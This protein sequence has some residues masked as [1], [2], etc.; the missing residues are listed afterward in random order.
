[1]DVNTHSHPPD[2]ETYMRSQT[3][4]SI[5]QRIREDPMQ[6]MCKVYEAVATS[7]IDKNML[8]S[9]DSLRSAMRRERAI[10]VPKL[11]K[12]RAEIVLQEEWSHTRNGDNFVIPNTD[13]TNDILMFSTSKNLE[14]LV[15]CK[16][17]YIDGTFKTCPKLYTQLFTMHGL[18]ID[19]VVPLVY[20]LLSDKR[21]DTYY[22]VLNSIRDAVSGLGLVFNP[23]TI[24]SDFEAGFIDAIRKQF[25]NATHS[26][27][28]FHFAQAIWRKIQDGGLVVLYRLDAEVCRFVQSCVALAFVPAAEV[29][30][31][32]EQ[33]LSELTETN[34]VL[35]EGFVQYFRYTWLNGLYSISMWNKYGADHLHRT[36]NAVESWHAGLNRRLPS[37]PNIFVF[38]SEIKRR[39]SIAEQAMQNAD[40]CEDRPRRKVKYIKLEKRLLKLH[41]LHSTKQIDTKKLLQRVRHCNK[42]FN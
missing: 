36:N 1:M 27:C 23:E 38:V 13:A 32:F 37:H 21:S 26:G 39:Q 16:T 42:K 11:P 6:E 9:Y 28:H 2:D 10:G 14:N 34:R 30:D 17:V 3:V 15:Q 18:Y 29:T 5:R 25:P 7:T 31:Q 41:T 8:P 4:A 33:L 35:V 24:L 22:K 40:N 12:T 20:V 19:T